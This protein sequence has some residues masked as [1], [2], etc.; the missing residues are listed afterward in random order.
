MQ[1]I[2]SRTKV[3]EWISPTSAMCTSFVGHLVE[4]RVAEMQHDEAGAEA[5]GEIDGLKGVP[6][7]A[8]A[9]AG[10]GGGDW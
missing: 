5:L 1:A 3:R 9:L 8:V 10:I 7:G 2:F 4:R 6:Q